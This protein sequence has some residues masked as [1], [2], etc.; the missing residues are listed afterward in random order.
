MEHLPVSFWEV[1]FWWTLIGFGLASCI[2][3]AYHFWKSRA[4]WDRG[5][6][7]FKSLCGLYI[8][9]VYFM[10][11]HPEYLND[12]WYVKQCVRGVVFLFSL[13]LILD[14]VMRQL[15]RKIGC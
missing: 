14:A 9:V 8:A 12:T 7:F 1:L 4:D 10:I 2:W 13:C 15:R 5:Y 3:Y 6:L 11:W